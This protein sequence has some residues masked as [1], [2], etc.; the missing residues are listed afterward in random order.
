MSLTAQGRRPDHGQ[1]GKNFTKNRGK[2]GHKP[3]QAWQREVQGE[4][5]PLMASVRS[6]KWKS[7]IHWVFSGF[8]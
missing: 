3:K 6:L 4:G 7:S 8:L 1:E 5:I 2:V